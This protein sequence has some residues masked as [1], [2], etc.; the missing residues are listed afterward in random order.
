[1]C[2]HR[3]LLLQPVWQPFWLPSVVLQ[4]KAEFTPD[5]KEEHY[6]LSW[7]YLLGSLSHSFFNQLKIYKKRFKLSSICCPESYEAS[8]SSP[9]TFMP[10]TS[11]TAWFSEQR[12]QETWILIIV[13]LDHVHCVAFPSNNVF[14]VGSFKWGLYPQKFQCSS[15]LV[16][17]Y[18]LLM[19]Q[20][21]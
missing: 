12:N 4:L 14:P 9:Y 6:I 18:A 2:D 13:L 15:K 5:S 19:Q 16:R 21:P 10:N 7:F 20:F 1:M 17:L 11:E 3:V 8:N